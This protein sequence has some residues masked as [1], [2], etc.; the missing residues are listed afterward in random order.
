MVQTTSSIDVEKFA[1]IGTASKPGTILKIRSL[2]VSF[3]KSGT[4]ASTVI[5]PSFFCTSILFSASCVTCSP[6]GDI[7]GKTKAAPFVNFSLTL[8]ALMT[9][10]FL[11]IT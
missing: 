1:R 8:F 2:F 4:F 5:L 11:S 3:M 9:V 6:V 10:L 7:K